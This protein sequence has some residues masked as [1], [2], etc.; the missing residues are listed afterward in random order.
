MTGEV[1]LRGKLLPVGGIKEKVLAAARGGIDTVIMPKRNEQD[2]ED[3]PLAIR[4]AMNFVFVESIDE[5][6]SYAL[7][8]PSDSDNSDTGHDAPAAKSAETSR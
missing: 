5:A 6:L 2:L 1:T 3:A 4:D 8:S 7:P